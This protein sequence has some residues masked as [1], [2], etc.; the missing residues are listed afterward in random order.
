MIGRRELLIGG[1]CL[2][3]AA[4]AYGLKPRHEISVLGDRSLNEI[5]PRAFGDW[6]SQ[7]VGGLVAPKIEGSLADR[8]YNEMVERVYVNGETGAQI[9]VLMAHGDRNT[10]ALQLHRPESCYPA[11]GFTLSSNQPT[12]IPL[13][14]DVSIPGRRLVADAPG[15]RESIVY[16]TRLGEYLPINS[17]EQRRDRLRTAMEGNVPD[18]LL[19][20]FSA[21]GSSPDATL[22]LLQAFVPAL[23]LSTPAEGRDALIG[24][25]RARALARQV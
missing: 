24:S 19:A 17:G 6:T 1:G 13:A 7:D 14:Q 22:D 15:R 20:R 16:W 8:L 5:V 11:F 25:K 3:A 18:G 2:V 10:D 21:I 23:V 12:D 4:A 9:M